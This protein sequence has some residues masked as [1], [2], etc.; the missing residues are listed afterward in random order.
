M[1][2]IRY[3]VAAVALVVLWQA[4]TVS[5]NYQGNWTALFCTGDAHQTPP[6]LASEQIHVFANSDGFDAQFYHYIAHEPLPGGEL[7]PYVEAPRMRYARILLPGMSWLL[8]AGQDGAIHIAFIVTGLLFLF[9]GVFW[10]SGH[11]ESIG[12]H[13]AWGLLFALVPASIVFADRLTIDH[14]LAAL[15]M[16]F[17]FYNRGRPSW[18]LFM[19]LMLAPLARE[20]GLI[21]TGAYVLHCWIRR[22][23]KTGIVFGISALPWLAWFIYLSVTTPPSHYASSMIPFQGALHWLINPVA[24]PPDVPLQGLI[25]AGDVLALLGMVLAIALAFLTPRGNW[26]EATT[27]AACVFALMAVVLQRLDVWQTVYNFGRIFSPLVVLV[28]VSWL[29]R[30]R[31]LAILPLLLMAPRL[32]M[33]YGRQLQGISEA[34][35]GG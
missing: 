20:T 8:A 5:V 34:L 29:P 11:A 18:Q 28:V 33:Q 10:L 30:R 35:L 26:F 16:A 13:P 15:T 14:A 7:Y 3:A 27:I 31:W 9:L 6:Q 25:Q 1:A 12:L 23:W 21:L 22:Q 19:V 17:A 2:R 32:L 4:V 24:Y